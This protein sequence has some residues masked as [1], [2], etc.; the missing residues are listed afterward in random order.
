MKQIGRIAATVVAAFAW[1]VLTIACAVGFLATFEVTGR[2]RLSWQLVY[3][4]VMIALLVM[5][6][7]AI[8][9]L[10]RPRRP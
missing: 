3:A 5:L 4:G 9:L 7:G 10:W 2:T 8:W 6:A 1:T